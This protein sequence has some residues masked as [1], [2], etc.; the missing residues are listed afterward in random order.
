MSRRM[1]YRIPEKTHKEVKEILKDEDID[2]DEFIDLLIDL[3]LDDK[4]NPKEQEEDWGMWMK[5][6]N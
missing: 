3:Y 6:K 2:F 4:I 5:K 1:A